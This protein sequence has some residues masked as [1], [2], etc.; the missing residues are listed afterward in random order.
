M[1]TLV[2]VTID[3]EEQWDWNAGWDRQAYSLDNIRDM[4]RFEERC[5]CHG[6][7][8]TWFAD[9]AVMEHAPSRDVM[10]GLAARPGVELGMHIHPWIIP[11]YLSDA[12]CG[13]RESY[14]HN[15]TPEQVHAK[16]SNVYE[17]FEDQG[18]RPRS[19]RGGR[20]SSGGAI[21]DFLRSK[22]FVADSSVVPFTTWPDDGAPDFHD[23]DLSP[24]RVGA[25]PSGQG[26]WEVPL[27]LGFTRPDFRR[28]ADRFEAIQRSALRRLRLIGILGKLGFVQRVWLNFECTRA[29]AMLALLRV[30][31][32]MQLPHLILTVHSTSLVPGGNPYSATEER[33]RQIWATVDQVLGTVA[34]WDE[35]RP[36]TV[37][38]IADTLEAEYQRS[39]RA[40]ARPVYAGTRPTGP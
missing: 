32:P 4:P 21:H 7:R 23:R 29:D 30:L 26:L 40:P 12:A 34:S 37:G 25:S 22:N 38:E 16:L 35:V 24:R 5:A 39:V 2:A 31:R 9:S 11:P 18:L 14:L 19:F 1:P 13:P 20:Y 6:M 3:T 28:W 15:H 10:L 27:T 17:L 8:T 33:V 36:A